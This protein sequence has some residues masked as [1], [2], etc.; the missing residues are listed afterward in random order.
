MQTNI[1]R[2]H[3]NNNTKEATAILEAV[4]KFGCISIEQAAYFMPPTLI[5]KEKYHENIINH[6]VYTKQLVKDGDAVCSP[7]C[8]YAHKETI[9]SIWAMIE[10]LERLSTTDAPIS[11]ALEESYAGTKPETLT[12]I[13]DGS[14]IIHT[15]PVYSS[16]DIT[17]ILFAQE[18]YYANG[19]KHGDEENSNS[20]YY[21]VLR[22]SK[23]LQDISKL[24][25]TFPYKIA[26][27]TD[28]G[29]ARPAIK[30]LQP[31]KKANS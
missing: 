27:L 13:L 5:S 2:N 6:F 1:R 9:D 18:K 21:F 12:F 15:I 8:K 22:D 16:G 10:I 4:S 25:L 31:P 23:F 14:K 3:M 24:N 29:N 20:I 11:E 28:N 19:H 30:L 26:Y 17:S 7:N